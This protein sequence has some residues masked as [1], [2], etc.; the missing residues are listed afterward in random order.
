MGALGVSRETAPGP[1]AR[2][3][4]AWG[5]LDQIVSSGA[6]FIF[7]VAVARSV[8]PSDFGSVALAFEVY[9]LTVIVT[10]GV[11]GDTLIA[12]FSGRGDRDIRAAIQASSG[13]SLAIALIVAA[14]AA[15]SAFLVAPQLRGA[16]LVLALTL[17]LLTLQDFIRQCLIV[18]GRARAAFVNDLA[19]AI[20]QLP[21][22]W[23]AAS[24]SPTGPALLAAW[25]GVGAATA[26][27]GAVQL[28]VGVLRFRGARSWLREQ[29]TLWPYLLGENLLYAAGSFV[30]VLTIS[31][32]A[33]LTGVAAF[34][35]AMTIYAPL[36]TLGRGVMSV[37]VSLLARRRGEP[38]WIRRAAL[39]LSLVMAPTAFIWGAL[40]AALPREV[41]EAGFGQTWASAEPLV[42]LASFPCAIALFSVGTSCG[43]R[44]LDAG[45]HGFGARA[46]VSSVALAAFTVGVLAGGVR[47]AF[48]VFAWSTPLQALIWWWL[49]NSA[50]RRAEQ[51]TAN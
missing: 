45:G 19:W 22:L 9:L 31:A 15:A 51:I 2:T 40:F 30:V 26:V 44:A 4:A 34:R 37:A 48:E 27:L 8:A 49:L 43:M 38:A 24:L 12:R 39:T 20:L 23:V 6:N 32:T 3:H 36:A 29:R 41:G 14:T 46:A 10:R 1:R 47:A 42:F 5:V 28:R 25:G 7:I 33:G 13:A 18:Q 21:A 50:A 35:A 11:A 16:L 17:P